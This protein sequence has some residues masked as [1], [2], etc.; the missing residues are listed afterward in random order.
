MH[1][2]VTSWHGWE[3][4]QLGRHD[5][6]QTIWKT[7]LDHSTTAQNLTA[8]AYLLSKV[9]LGADDVGDHELALRCHQE[10]ADLFTRTHD[11][12][13]LGYTLS[14]LSWTHR[15]LGDFDAA[16][17]AATDA[18]E[19]FERVNHRW[20]IGASLGR[21]AHAELDAG[22]LA[23][24]ATDFAR[25]IDWG[26]AKQMPTIV[27]YGLV[28]I[29]LCSLSA[30]DAERA[31]ELFAH[32]AL[33][34][35]NPYAPTFAVPGLAAAEAQLPSDEFERARA[36]GEALDLESAKALARGYARDLGARTAAAATV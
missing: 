9:G 13:G 10:S 2:A 32:N 21:R 19:C 11:N 16:M 30:D 15:M 4:S 12:G 1:A 29:G 18:L 25:C 34:P 20:G 22:H 33:A 36:R 26:E 6:A 24:A 5:E 17:Q 31:V 7:G 23:E 35:Q 14:R 8:R 3:L 27:L 28:G